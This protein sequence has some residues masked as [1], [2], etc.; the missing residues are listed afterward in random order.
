MWLGTAGPRWKGPGALVQRE[1][2]PLL[3][4]SGGPH[5]GPAPSF[6]GQV[7]CCGFH[8]KMWVIPLEKPGLGG[9]ERWRFLGLSCYPL[10]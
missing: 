5:E 6:W 10:S 3:P 7:G 1:R 4:G 9:F 8:R 2:P